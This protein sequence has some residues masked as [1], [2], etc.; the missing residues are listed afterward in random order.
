MARSC[1]AA[2]SGVLYPT[3]SR[4]KRASWALLALNKARNRRSGCFVLWDV[5]KRD[6]GGRNPVRFTVEGRN[7]PPHLEGS[8]APVVKFTY[9]LSLAGLRSCSGS[10][11]AA[12][13]G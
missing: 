11:R 3:I 12:L 5:D 13:L 9:E 1:Y 10:A 4:S 8:A 7:V 6:C 2:S